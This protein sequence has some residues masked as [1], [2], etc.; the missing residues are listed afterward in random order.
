MVIG[1]DSRLIWSASTSSI[2]QAAR[3]SRHDLREAGHY[4][5]AE[6]NGA[7]RFERSDRGEGTSTTEFSPLRVGV[8][9]VG[10]I[11]RLHAELLAHD[12][13]G[14]A[15]VAVCDPRRGRARAVAEDL[16]ARVSAS[17]EELIRDPEV[18]AV[19]ICS[20]TDTHA[21]LVIEAAA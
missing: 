15:L 17:A 4:R 9:G 1:W 14:A 21:K 3:R 2:P 11:G 6:L 19:G 10:R 8:L 13:A 12:V 18:K 7:S 16:G 20:S 5:V